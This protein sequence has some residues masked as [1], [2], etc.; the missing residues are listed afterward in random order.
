[1]GWCSCRSPALRFQRLQVVVER[2]D[3]PHA[4]VN[5]LAKANLLDRPLG[6][7]RRLSD[8]IEVFEPDL[9]KGRDYKILHWLGHE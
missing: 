1:V 5:D 6:N 2:F 3:V 8:G 7:L 9:S 4:G